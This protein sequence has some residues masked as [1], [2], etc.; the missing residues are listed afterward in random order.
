MLG[1]SGGGLLLVAGMYCEWHMLLFPSFS[2][3]L[4][5]FGCSATAA[6]HVG[7]SLYHELRQGK[8]MLMPSFTSGFQK[9][10]RWLMAP[11]P[12]DRPNAARILAS[13]LLQKKT[14][15]RDNSRENYGALP[16]Q[17]IMQGK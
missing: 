11:A 8:L 13:S 16:L 7:G 1:V 17:P 12:R 14:H 6:V 5:P 10:L 4:G 3:L 9:M 2:T 15:Q